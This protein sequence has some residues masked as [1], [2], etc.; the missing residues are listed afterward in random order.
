MA[1]VKGK[2]GPP[3]NMNAFIVS[4]GVGRVPGNF[5]E[6]SPTKDGSVRCL[7][8]RRGEERSRMRRDEPSRMAL[9]D[10]D[11]IEHLR[12]RLLERE[13]DYEMALTEIREMI[14]VLATA[15]KLL[16]GV[17]LP[18]PPGM[19]RREAELHQQHGV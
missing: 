6:S 15:P 17:K 10:N 7:L 13:R 11:H 5:F 18:G 1:G 19:A 9:S 2:S 8:F 4:I 12:N 14:R 16:A 3:S